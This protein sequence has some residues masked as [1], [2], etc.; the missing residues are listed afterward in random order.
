MARENAAF[1]THYQFNLAGTIAAATTALGVTA[2]D[3]I[4]VAT[5]TAANIVLITLPDGTGK[6]DLRF[7]GGANNDGIV[8]NVYGARSSGDK[9][10]Y[11]LIG[12]LTLTVGQQAGTTG[13]F[14]DTIVPSVE[15]TTLG[16]VEFSPANDDVAH[17]V[18]NTLGY[19]KLLFIDTTH[20]A[21]KITYIDVARIE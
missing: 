16:A 8:M 6:I 14:V 15:D 2:R 5:L 18:L 12:T 21:G 3:S 13:L 20:P 17:Y 4:S 9:Y 7:R 1:L 10:H 19:D 11:H